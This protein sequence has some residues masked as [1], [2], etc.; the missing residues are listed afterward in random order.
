[1]KACEI[2]SDLKGM[3]PNGT[4]SHLTVTCFFLVV[5]SHFS[6]FKGQRD[7]AREKSSF[8]RRRTAAGDPQNTRHIY[9]SVHST[10]STIVPDFDVGRGERT[11]ER[12]QPMSVGF[13]TLSDK[14]TM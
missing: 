11:A 14:P 3:S 4:F 9:V 1:M 5:F 2:T 10:A 13:R 12:G 8:S 7:N 6:Y